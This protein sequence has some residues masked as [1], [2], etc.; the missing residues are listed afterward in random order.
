MI[1]AMYQSGFTA[2]AHRGGGKEEFEN[3][4]RAF[5][6]AMDL[7]YAVIETDVQ[8]SADGTIYIFHDDTLDRTTTGHGVFSAKTDKELAALT[9]NNGE[10]IPRLLDLLTACPGVIFNIDVKTDD[11]IDAMA[12]FLN[13]HGHHD[14]ICLASFSTKRLNQIRRKLDK[15]CAMSGGQ[16]DVLR[17]Y[18]GAFGLPM[19]RPDV[20]AAQVPVSA[21]GLT[22]ITPRFLRHCRKLDIA[23]H[24]WT[25]DDAAE[26]TRLIDLGVD[27]IVTDCPS[28]LKDIALHKKVWREEG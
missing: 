13:T 7:G 11:G 6:H 20:V 28:Q 21:Y 9:L 14:R 10:A 16:M 12:G 22:I 15:P 24:V 8:V 1:S 2:L 17:L 25:I 26:M 19:G 5:R 4:P 18:L 3:S 23:V 27:G